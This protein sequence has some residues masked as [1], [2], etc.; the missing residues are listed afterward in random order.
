[1][2]RLDII[3]NKHALDLDQYLSFPSSQMACSSSSQTRPYEAISPAPSPSP[4]GENEIGYLEEPT[5]MPST[6]SAFMSPNEF[7]PSDDDGDL[8]SSVSNKVTG[9]RP[10]TAEPICND[11]ESQWNPDISRGS[12]AIPSPFSEIITEYKTSDSKRHIF[13]PLKRFRA[14]RQEDKAVL[15]SSLGETRE[16][17]P[18]KPPTYRTAVLSRRRKLLQ[19]P[20]TMYLL[21]LLG[22]L[23]AISHH[24]YYNSLDGE[25]ADDQLNKLRYG[26][27]LAFTAKAGLVTAVVISFK[28]RIW[29]TMRNKVLSVDALDS[30]FAATDSFAAMFNV[31]VYKHAKIAM[32]LAIFVWGTPLLL[33]ITSTTLT[34]SM[35]IQNGT[36]LGVQTLNFSQE[37]SNNWRNPTYIDGFEK[38]PLSIWNTTAPW[39]VDPFSQEPRPDWFDFYNGPG[40]T[41]TQLAGYATY[42][43]KPIMRDTPIADIC[44]SGW[45]CS[46]TI[47]FNGPGYNCKEVASGAGS[48]VQSLGD[49]KPPEGFTT[50]LLLPNGDSSYNV[51][52]LGAEYS[53]HQVAGEVSYFGKPLSDPPY[54]KTLGAWRAEPVIWFGYVMKVADGPLP[55]NSSVPG[56]N[57]SFVPKVLACENWETA[58]TVQ[59]NHTEAG[60]TIQVKS[61]QY[62]HKLINTTWDQSKDAIDGTNDN[63]TAYPASNYVFPASLGLY[64]RISAFH[65]L[66][67]VFRSWING[68]IYSMPINEP[69]LFTNAIDTKLVDMTPYHLP[70]SNVPALLQSLFEDMLLSLLSDPQYLAV[71][72]A[73]D[74]SVKVGQNRT[75]ERF[76]Y[77][78]TKT[79]NQNVFQYH[80]L[81]LWTVYGLA[82][83]LA[84][85]C[86]LVGRHAVRANDGGTL[87]DTKFSTIVAATRERGLD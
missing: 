48:L 56:W 62:L 59:F 1:M 31:E 57:E 39:Y 74:P 42:S 18:L 6:K 60:Q 22:I 49:Q 69:I 11:V 8:G 30:L 40:E 53:K 4:Q 2:V 64:R 10:E 70:D 12:T 66:G 15:L 55:N 50:D 63:I 73:A 72:W 19:H 71:V 28:Q 29:H 33:V 78:C 86:V 13:S 36:C 3:D 25:P 76:V 37:E 38:I 16:Q 32:L 34:V 26:V 84:G 77:P 23:G 75:D 44:G 43:K 61:R 80:V 41:Y 47:Q 83:I 81:D 7:I 27:V 54:P 68:T 21:Y 5:T 51:Y 17:I 9:N 82:I 85:A 79:R 52:A 46:Y 87:R 24:L 35:P 20:V 14:S 58:Y 65:S 67:L 45:S